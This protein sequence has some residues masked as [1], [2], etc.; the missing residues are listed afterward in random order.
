V[1]TG[2]NLVGNDV[3]I[4]VAVIDGVSVKFSV[5]GTL[6]ATFTTGLPDT[7]TQRKAVLLERVDDGNG[8]GTSLAIYGYA[9]SY[10]A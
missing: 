7:T 9:I 4:T 10:D 6:A 3:T 5:D 2:V 1:L 8:A